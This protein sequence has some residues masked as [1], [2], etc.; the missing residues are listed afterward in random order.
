ME[1]ELHFRVPRS[2]LEFCYFPSLFYF[3]LTPNIDKA[4][5]SCA[6]EADVAFSR[7][8]RTN[9]KDLSETSHTKVCVLSRHAAERY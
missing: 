9:R 5:F 2:M 1:Q 8:Y 4:V 6:E 7:I 3:E